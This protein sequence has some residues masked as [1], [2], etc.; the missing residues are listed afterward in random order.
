MTHHSEPRTGRCLCGAVE[1]VAT[2]V[3]S[4]FGGCHCKMCQR[5]AGSAL[6][7]LTVK[8]EAIRF[9]GREHIATFASS[10]W[11][12]RAWC[13][14]C[15]SGLWYR[16]TS[17]PHQGAYEIPIGLFDETH[18]LTMTR[19]IF[20]DRKPEG[21]AFAGDHKRMT[22]AEVLALYAPKEGA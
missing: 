3:A 10:E 2:D 19:E 16:V 7:A 12:E 9:T 14:K 15:G 11:A 21:Y 6:L 1:F 17:G 8:D 20:I 13:S 22:E 18:G 4:E 5:W